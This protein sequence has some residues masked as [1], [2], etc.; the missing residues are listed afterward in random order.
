MSSSWSDPAPAPASHLLGWEHQ[1]RGFL[2]GPGQQAGLKELLSRNEIGGAQ[3]DH[4]NSKG[5]GGG[6]PRSL[7]VHAMDL[8]DQSCEKVFE[9]LAL[10]PIQT[11]NACDE[12]LLQMAKAQQRLLPPDLRLHFRVRAYPVAEYDRSTVPKTEDVGLF[13]TLRGTVIKMGLAHMLETQKMFQCLK[14]RTV[15]PVQADFEQFYRL[16]RP[17][18]CPEYES[19]CQNTYNFAAVAG[20]DVNSQFCKDYQEIKIQEQA[21]DS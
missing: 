10:R 18:R 3:E 4:S 15:F 13:L 20:T 19:G 9:S 1:F 16:D 12:I 17:K 8:L 7:V 5:G 21:R 11:L 14:C 6:L 2:R